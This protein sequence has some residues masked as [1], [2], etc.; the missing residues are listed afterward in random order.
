MGRFDDYIADLLLNADIQRLARRG[1]HHF[2]INR[3]E[4]SLAAAKLSYVVARFINADARVCARAGMLHDW[5]FENRDEHQNRA[6]ANIHHYKISA[7]NARGIGESEAVIRA[8]ET[9]M[10][11]YVRG[12]PRSKEAWIIWMADNVVWLTDGAW[13]F[14]RYC[15][16]KARHFIYGHSTHQHEPYAF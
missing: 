12:K 9:H 15:K 8:I 14:A 7:A 6:G 16:K 5:F 11:L 3:L 13:S 4:H 2:S 1:A 10:W